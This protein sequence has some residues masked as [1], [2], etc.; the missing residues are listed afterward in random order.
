[1]FG[2]TKKRMVGIA[3]AFTAAVV[4]VLAAAMMAWAGK[5]PVIHH[6][7]VGGP[8]ACEAI[9]FDH[10]GC[11]ANFSLVANQKADGSVSG[12]WTDRFGQSDGFHATVDC[13]S[14]VGNTAWIGGVVTNG[15]YFGADVVGQRVVTVV[16]DNGNN[17][18]DPPDK[19]SYSF[20]S[21][22]SCTT[23]FGA[24]LLNAP[25]GQVKVD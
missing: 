16:Q 5:G 21:N 22:I 14:I 4:V 23:H 19:I 8:D 6:V 9:G 1:M 20:L 7:S 15:T 18:N 24:A 2:I 12:Q 13:L 10:P 11:N 3:S 25:D 17:A